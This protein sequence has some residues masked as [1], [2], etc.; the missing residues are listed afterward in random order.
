M[1]R[2]N[3]VV[4]ITDENLVP[5][6]L[7]LWSRLRSL[8]NRHDTDV[9]LFMPDNLVAKYAPKD[10]GIGIES[11]SQLSLP[12]IKYSGPSHVTGTACRR[13]V[14]PRLLQDRYAKLLYL[15]IDVVVSDP[16]LFQVF[17]AN[18]QSP[19]AATRWHKMSFDPSKVVDGTIREGEFAFRRYFNSGV[20]LI[21]I[22]R[23]L[24]AEVDMKALDFL[25]GTEGRTYLA[26]QTALNLAAGNNW[27]ELTPAMNFRA[28]LLPTFFADVFP[29]VV[30]HY[31]GRDKPWHPLARAHPLRSAQW[32]WLLS[33]GHWR[34]LLRNTDLRRLAKW[35]RDKAKGKPAKTYPY[36][37]PG[38]PLVD[39]Y[40]AVPFVDHWNIRN[41]QQGER[42]TRL[43]SNA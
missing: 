38:N 41:A 13:I 8:N 33:N 9:I 15:D 23:Y 35:L 42:D 18:M 37:R 6:A 4:L 26:D 10:G 21:D 22:D 24:E 11:I 28:E 1:N 29:P 25:T 31:V 2:R 16:S 14:A 12:D 40:L 20:M 43:S 17:E 7:H 27:Q 30:I 39:E 32:G 34:F 5:P 36:I 3:V 19:L